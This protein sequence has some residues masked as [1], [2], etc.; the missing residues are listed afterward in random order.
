MAVFA[1][2]TS[3]NS[4]EV[5]KDKRHEERASMYENE[6]ATLSYVT[7][8]TE[9]EGIYSCGHEHLTIGEAL[10]CLVPDG[11]SFIRAC[12][13][14]VVRSLNDLEMGIFL[15]ELANRRGGHRR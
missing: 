13:H 12:D 7:C 4:I 8:W 11:R 5:R 2:T 15:L 6:P 9:T 3:S 1:S 14:G 10:G